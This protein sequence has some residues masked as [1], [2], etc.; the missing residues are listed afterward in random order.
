[1]G[2]TK[3]PVSAGVIRRLGRSLEDEESK[4]EN[5]KV[6]EDSKTITVK[7]KVHIALDTFISA[8]GL[9]AGQRG[10]ESGITSTGEGLEDTYQEVS[11]SLIPIVTTALPKSPGAVEYETDFD[12]VE[13]EGGEIDSVVS[14]GPSVRSPS[15]N[16]IDTFLYLSIFGWSKVM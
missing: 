2:G 7:V 12:S 13:G 14:P 5:P 15:G 16:I 1:V 8:T 10:E 4:G 11:K 9:S 3:G 6:L